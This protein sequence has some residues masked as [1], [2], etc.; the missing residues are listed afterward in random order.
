MFFQNS[1]K[2][3][4]GRICSSGAR[5]C[6]ALTAALSRVWQVASMSS[7]RSFISCFKSSVLFSHRDRIARVTEIFPTLQRNRHVAVFPNEIM[8]GAQVELVALLQARFGEEFC[9]LQFAHLVGD[10]L[11]GPR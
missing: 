10:G 8:K 1:H 7:S 5:A 11:T 2:K 3:R 6:F 9:D 4:T